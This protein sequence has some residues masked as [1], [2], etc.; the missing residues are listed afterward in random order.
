VIQTQ[1]PINP[2]NSGG[3]LFNDQGEL[4]GINT[5]GGK[6][7]GINFAVSIET[8][9]DFLA[10]PVTTEDAPEAEEKMPVKEWVPWRDRDEDGEWDVWAFDRD[11]NGVPQQWL[12]D[13][14]YNGRPEVLFYDVDENDIVERAD[15]SDPE[16]LFFEAEFFRFD[17][18][19]DGKWDEQAVDKD[20]DWEPDVFQTIFDEEECTTLAPMLQ[21][22]W[23]DV[24]GGAEVSV[25]SL[26]NHCA[27]ELEERTERAIILLGC[28]RKSEGCDVMTSCADTAFAQPTDSAQ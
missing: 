25:D 9:S 10:D 22:C 2:G 15:Y 5:F 26:V 7:E 1:T 18:D 16:N 8:I 17:Y 13:N 6:G 21:Q 19:Q 27:T 23:P 3:P 28:M 14:D 11:G 4:V 12:L 20:G 24:F